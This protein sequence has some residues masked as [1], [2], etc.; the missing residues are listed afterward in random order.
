MTDYE[1]LEKIIAEAYK[2]MAD[3]STSSGARFEA[4]H[5]SAQRFLIQKYGKDS[6]EYKKFND[7]SFC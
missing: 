6:F 7:T 4:W 1:K 2:L 5:T 3:E